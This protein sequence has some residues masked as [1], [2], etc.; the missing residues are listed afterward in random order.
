M[1]F[2]D[3]ITFGVAI[4]I[5]II[6]VISRS[7]RAKNQKSQQQKSPTIGESESRK[8]AE[9]WREITL[10]PDSSEQII[11]DV[12]TISNSKKTTAQ[13]RND[14]SHHNVKNATNRTLSK[15]NDKQGARSTEDGKS[16]KFN[17]RDAVIYSEIL[18][19]KF[20]EGE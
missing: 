4:I 15:A 13:A 7:S 9:E 20:K 12:I 3:I 18:T 6:S 5:T 8:I 14:A 19:P 2:E 1:N 11:D 16:T 10:H 17:L